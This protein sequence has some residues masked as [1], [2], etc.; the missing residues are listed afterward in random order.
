[1]PDATNIIS[2]ERG[3]TTQNRRA[4]IQ[5]HLIKGEVVREFVFAK[6][7]VTQ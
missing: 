5:R 4:I 1:M 6:S 2:V 3:G 7:L